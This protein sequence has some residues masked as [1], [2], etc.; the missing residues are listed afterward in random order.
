MPASAD[1]Y[2]LVGRGVQQPQDPLNT[3]AKTLQIQ[4][5]QQ[6]GQDRALKQ[7]E[8]RRG[9]EQK[10]KLMQLL[11]GEYAD[12]EER[13]SALLRGGFLKESQD[14]LK[15]RSDLR[16]TNADVAKTGAETDA[17]RLEVASK[18]LDIA[19]QA[20][21]YVKD[22]PSVESA[23]AAI[24]HL[25]SNGIW[26]QTQAEQAMAR[27]MAD[28]SPEGIRKLATMAYQSA[29]SAKDQL[30]NFVQQN[31]GGTVA[32]QRINPI[33]GV[34]ADVQS[35]NVTESEAQRLARE[36]A[37]A[38]AA[39]GRAVQIRGQDLVNAR[40]RDQ[41]AAGKLQYDAERG[42]VVNL[43]TGEFTPA[44]QGGKAIPARLPESTK[45]EIASI[46]AQMSVLD[47]ALRD[48][49]ATPGA[50][51][52]KRGL[53]TLAGGIPESIAGRTD[54]PGERDAR[55]YVFN[56]VSKVI[57]ERAGAAQSAQELARLRSFLPAET[58]N[59]EQITDKLNSFKGYLADLGNGYQPGRYQPQQPKSPKGGAMSAED[60]QARDWAM[61]NPNDPRAKQIM[62]RLG[63]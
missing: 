46:D 19:G 37:A 52:F 32:T 7:D 35:A 36:R 43:N 12:D 33:T 15:G 14:Y 41:V 17:K 53:A 28:Q 18:K 39:A 2:G 34:V 20:M 49:S 9:V 54:S 50:F 13:A 30:P 1:I 62:Q 6:L 61:K 40:A 56:V 10:N 29:L 44:T 5:M 42:G 3:L 23:K 45:K 63:G 16:K 31:R 22:N 27:V 8:Y 48:V 57:N 26:D 47:G 21:G 38:D 24:Q 58:D 55:S 11:G 59:A 60:T 25:V 4:E 51:T